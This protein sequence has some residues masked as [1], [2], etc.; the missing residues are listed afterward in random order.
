MRT[1]ISI[2]CVV[3]VLTGGCR[4]AEPK[5]PQS[6]EEKLSAWYAAWAAHQPRPAPQLV[7]RIESLLAKE[8]CVGSLDR[9]SRFYAYD[10]LPE[11]TVDAGIVDF[12][13]E[14]AGKMGIKPGVH[15]TVPDSW[16]NLDDRPIKMAEGD[17]DIAE[18][19]I[20][21]GSCGENVGIPGPGGFSNIAA[22]LRDLE[23]RRIAHGTKGQTLSAGDSKH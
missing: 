4:K 1:M 9:W 21:F 2:F 22:Y 19:R 17:F 10:Y 3:V 14:E 13:L 15:I 12:H 23:R 5:R 7:D 6:E 20:R 8:P 18:N 11:R 16:V